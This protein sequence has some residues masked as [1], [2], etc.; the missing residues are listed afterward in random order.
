MYPM[1]HIVRVIQADL[2][3]NNLQEMIRCYEEPAHSLAPNYVISQFVA[4][5]DVTVVLNGLGGDELFG[6]YHYYRWIKWRR[7]LQLIAPLIKLTRGIGFRWQRL[8]E[9]AMANSADRFHSVMIA[10]QTE[11]SKQALFKDTQVRDFNSVERL[12]QLYIRD[13]MGFTDEIEALSYM[14]MMNYIGNHHTYRVDQFTMRFSLEGR[15]PFLD[16]QLV[17]AAFSIPSHH[18]VRGNI[19]KYVLR[20]V[21]EDLI[22]PS[23]LVMKKKGFS[24]PVRRWMQGSLKNTVLENLRQLKE[25]DIFVAD[26]IDRYWREFEAGRR[27]HTQVWHL[28]AVEMWLSTFIDNGGQ[29]IW[30]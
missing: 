10:K 4:E 13:N 27:S 9:M 22:H 14:D 30:D 29:A 17:E 5:N 26:E 28:N 3:L 21:A 20:R 24:L 23:C 8:Y 11:Y 7:L 1:D 25:R 12:H 15:V 19:Q 2:I 18:K 6:G 16:H